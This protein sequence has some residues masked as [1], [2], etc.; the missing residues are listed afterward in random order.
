MADMEISKYKETIRACRYCPMCRHVCISGNL[1]F[2]ES[3]Y[4]RG[5]GLILDKINKG[6][7]KYSPDIAGPIYNCF[8]CGCCWANCEGGFEMHRL[9][10][11]SRKDIVRNGCQPAAASRIREMMLKGKNPYP[12]TGENLK[13]SNNPAN[14]I[15]EPRIGNID[16]KADI[17]YFMGDNIKYNFHDIAEKTTGVLDMLGADYTL[18][19]EEPTDGKI[20]KLLGFQEDA[21]AR[22]KDLAERIK[23]LEVKTIVVSDPLSYDAFKNDFYEYSIKL[24]PGIEHT[25]QVFAEFLEGYRKR[26]LDGGPEG[27]EKELK[28]RQIDKT[29]TLAD[30]EFLGRFNSVYEEPR[31]LVQAIAGSF[32][33]MRN[34][35]IKA[36]ATG[37]AAFI[38][39]D[40]FFE[41]GQQLGERICSEA[42]FAGAELVITLSATAKRNLKESCKNSGID[43]MEISEFIWEALSNKKKEV[44]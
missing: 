44:K 31:N 43:V 33:E 7:L 10:E 1:S 23:S 15:F 32:V 17:L 25:S 41:M 26:S 27:C 21:K 19:S 30:S 24:D 18:L 8:L 34:N 29:A 40:D 37:E 35:R 11:A 12:G 13:T 42:K 38:F 16:R 39:N 2:H 36:L 3:D 6:T 5:R 28:I 14:K 4:P 20:L 22:A 9:V